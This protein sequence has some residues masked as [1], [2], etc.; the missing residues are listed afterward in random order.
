[1]QNLPI[2][3]LAFALLFVFLKLPNTKRATFASFKETFDFLGLYALCTF[4]ACSQVFFCLDTS[5]T[6]A[7]EDSYLFF[8]GSTSS[9][10]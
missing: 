7:E 2:C 5:R 6:L 9:S 10:R 8:L 1:M 4:P 3:A